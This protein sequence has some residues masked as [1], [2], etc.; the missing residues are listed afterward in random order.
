MTANGEFS[1]T[2]ENQD[3]IHFEAGRMT[4]DKTFTGDLHGHSKGQM[5]SHRTQSGSAGYVA[6]E[7]VTGTLDGRMGTFSLQHSGTMHKGDTSQTVMSEF[8]A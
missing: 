6:I 3:D 7:H 1:V 4:L 5:L 8:P 2:L